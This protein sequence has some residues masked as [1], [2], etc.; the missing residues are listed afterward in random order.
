MTVSSTT[1]RVSYS[2]NGSTD[3]FTFTFPITA[4][5]Q[6]VVILV[7]DSTEVATTQTITTHYTVSA[8]PWES[9]GTIT[10]VTPP[11]SGETLIIMRV[12]PITQ[13]TDYVEND[14]FPADS[15]EEALDKLTFIAQQLDEELG[16]TLQ[17]SAGSSDSPTLPT[18][19]NDKYLTNDGDNLLWGTVEGATGALA[20]IVED[21]TPELGGHLG[22]QGFDITGLGTLSMTEQAA[23]NA[24]VA[25]DGQ[26]WV[27]TATPNE[28]WFTDDAGNDTKLGS[29][30]DSLS[31][32]GVLAPHKN[33][34]CKYV[35]V[36]TA[37][38]DAD[39]LLLTD[40]SG[41]KHMEGSINLT[42][43]ITASGANGLDTGSEA[44]GTWYHLWVIY[45]G[46][47]VAGLLSASA[48]SPT[49]PSG[50]TYKGYVG[51]VYNDSGSDF[52][53]FHQENGRGNYN[54]NKTALTNGAATTS[55]KVDI[56]VPPT[57]VCALVY[58]ISRQDTGV[59]TNTYAHIFSA[60]GDN[61]IAAYVGGSTAN[62]TFENY[63]VIDILLLTTD[64]AG[65][66]I[67]YKNN[68]SGQLTSLSVIGWRF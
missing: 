52:D 3:A 18:L 59:G 42:V 58:V 6:I 13:L 2:G 62:N 7:V 60:S 64:A 16:R 27:K 11:A 14:S 1:S 34:V 67:W 9:G 37:D 35:S 33:L 28:L 51:A 55:T 50:Y 15:H 30:I 23:A 47:T 31:A 25:G 40:S 22:G 39:E 20:N 44:A 49:L 66:D 26:L 21:V 46:T 17:M 24:D 43:D 56:Q 32:H 68:A 10:M 4:E 41:S 54:S 36:T 45:N 12:V 48:T 61:F 63:E 8:S 19:E 57:A 53:D 29:D 65:A 5:S 38:I